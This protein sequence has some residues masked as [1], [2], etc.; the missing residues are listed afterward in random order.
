MYN[1]YKNKGF[2]VFS[3]SLDK[4]KD[5]WLKAI[6]ADNL[7]WPNHVSDL[8]GWQSSAAVDYGVNAIPATF[9]IDQNG[10]IIGKNLRGPQLEQKLQ[11][12]FG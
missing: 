5:E 10:K 4:K 2:T 7:L 8:S 3:V 11:Q 1:Q 12:I 9:L 6:D